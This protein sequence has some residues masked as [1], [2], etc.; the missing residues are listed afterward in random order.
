MPKEIY[1]L[2]DFS[3][4]INNQSSPRDIFDNETAFAQDVIGDKTGILRTIGNG[5]GTPRQKDH[6][7][8]DKTIGTLASSPI[9]GSAGFGLKYFELDYDEAGNEEAGGE[10]YIALVD[11]GGELNLWDYTNASWNATPTSASAAVDL[12]SASVIQTIIT[13]VDDGIRMCDINFDNSSTCKYFMH[14]KRSQLSRDRSGFYGGANII[15][16]PTASGSQNELVGS[17]TYDD[18]EF[19]FQIDAQTTGSGTWR[20]DNYAFAITF[21][22]DGNQ[23]SVPSLV[24][25]TLALADVN[26]D[27]PLKVTVYAANAGGA[28]DYDARLTGARIY[29]KHYEVTTSLVEQGEWNLLVDIDIAG[30]ASDSNAFGIRGKLGDEF[31]DWSITSNQ[32]SASIIINDPS[33]D[34]YATLNGYASND[35]N[36]H[37]GNASDGYKS[38]VFANRRMFVGSVKK[39]DDYGVQRQM[40]DRIMYSPVN[41][42]DIF[43]LHNYVDVINSDAEPYV[44]LES[45]GG[46]LF[47]FKKDNLYILD[48]SNPS[49]SSWALDSTYR[50]MGVLSHGAVFKTDFGL[51]WVNPNGLFA[52]QSGGGITELTENK[53]LSGYTTDTYSKNSWGKLITSNSIIGYSSKDKEIVIALDPTSATANSTTFGGNGSDV[54]VY[55]VETKSFWYGLDRLHAGSGEYMSNFEYDW[56]GDL[57]YASET[58]DTITI[59]SWKSES[60]V[61]TSTIYQTRDFDFGMPGL[62]KKIYNVYITYKASAS[63]QDTGSD[64]IPFLYAV[65]GSKTFANFDTCTVGGS[66]STTELVASATNWDVATLSFTT[67]KSVQSFAIKL[68]NV[69]SGTLEINDVA[70]EY[71]VLNQKRVS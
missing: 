58:S 67:P 55:D 54:I 32:A 37:I 38:A 41:K 42:P 59:R 68:D 28:T 70:I 35:G 24:N 46:L 22:Y 3:G 48:I 10:H 71:R 8:S 60:Q 61:S 5:A 57:I 29:W 65:D 56:N 47:A 69:N 39:T 40:L 31:K 15:T 19:N 44:R 16:A 33:I 63:L 34:T 17:A 36:I 11:E 50:G 18:G 43:P 49:P 21:I 4:G 1:Y 64:D 45:V 20:K 62:I 51:I 13:A 2:R 52:Y 9:D 6:S 7:G 26:E 14:I 25:S 66:A 23:E 12:G 30:T 53:I 27:R